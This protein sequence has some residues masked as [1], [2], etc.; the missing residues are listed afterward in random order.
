MNSDTLADEHIDRLI[1]IA[2][3]AG[4]QIMEI[5]ETDF[6]IEH[7]DDASPLTEADQASHRVIVH[8]LQS[9]DSAIPIMSEEGCHTAYEERRTWA[10]YWLVDPLDGTKEFINRNGEFTVNIALIQGMYPVFGLIHVP[11]SG[12][13]YIGSSRGAYE[14]DR[15]HRKTS[16]QVSAPN[17]HHITIVESR[18]HPS[19]EV[20]MMM[21]KLRQ[22]FSNVDRIEKGSSLKLCV[23]ANGTAQLYPRL[24]PTMEW[25]IAAGHAI[26]EAAGGQVIDLEGQRIRYNKSDLRNSSFLAVGN[27]EPAHIQ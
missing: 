25:D 7:K 12:M 17:E 6:A 11:V 20:D 15:H 22:T 21:Y 14:I 18:S 26:V 13:T 19:P 2:R 10:T 16:I 8:G 9:V 3:A 27:W 5:Y 23:I 1:T 24:G 4:Q